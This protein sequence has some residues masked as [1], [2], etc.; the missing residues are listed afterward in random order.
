MTPLWKQPAE[1]GHRD[2]SLLLPPHTRHSLPLPP[3][4]KGNTSNVKGA[5][6]APGW[7]SCL[8]SFSQ[9]PSPEE[10]MNQKKGLPAPG[11]RV[12][13][14]EEVDPGGCPLS[15]SCPSHGPAL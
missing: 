10:G 2:T 9:A 12:N 15:S 1:L 4:A 7:S 11:R 8:H 6:G 3:S 14:G 5:E 13:A